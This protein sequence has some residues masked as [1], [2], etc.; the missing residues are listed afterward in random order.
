MSVL[1]VGVCLIALSAK[2]AKWQE[3]NLFF[4][5]SSLGE[6]RLLFSSLGPA[7]G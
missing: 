5:G 1:Q 2:L 6:K 7:R 3:T 4:D